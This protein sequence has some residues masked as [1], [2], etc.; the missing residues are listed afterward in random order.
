MNYSQDLIYVVGNVTCYSERV[1]RFNLIINGESPIDELCYIVTACPDIDMK[2]KASKIAL[3]KY[4]IVDHDEHQLFNRISAIVLQDKSILVMSIPAYYP[5]IPNSLKASDLPNKKHNGEKSLADLACKNSE[6]SSLLINELGIA[7]TAAILLPSYAHLFYSDN[8][9]V[10]SVMDLSMSRQ[11]SHA[12]WFISCIEKGM[13][14]RTHDA[15]VFVIDKLY[16]KDG[17]HADSSYK[18]GAILVHI[19]QLTKYCP[20]LYIKAIA[21]KIL[22]RIDDF[23]KTELD[24][25]A[26]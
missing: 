21:T 22:N 15:A 19:E 6:Y 20:E 9:S 23:I 17:I 14:S 18:R 11:E 12:R 8:E 13:C 4:G 26:E 24:I 3:A 1:K 10:I 25:D 2:V 7:K 16:K 5:F